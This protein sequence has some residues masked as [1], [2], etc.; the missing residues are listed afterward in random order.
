[1]AGS[2]EWNESRATGD[3]VNKSLTVGANYNF[4]FMKLLGGFQANDDLV[5][6]SGNGA[7]IGNN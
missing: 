5:L 4:G 3:D 6:G 1:V 7:F 2:Y